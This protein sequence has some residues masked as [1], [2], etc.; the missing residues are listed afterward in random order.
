[1]TFWPSVSY[2]FIAATTDTI[3]P[4]WKAFKGYG[5]ACLMPK[6]RQRQR[7][8]LR[9]MT[10]VLQP[11][12]TAASGWGTKLGGKVPTMDATRTPA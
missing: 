7:H 8:A 2:A 10:D 5:G 3:S 9:A 12:G 4:P 1:M 6:P 11:V